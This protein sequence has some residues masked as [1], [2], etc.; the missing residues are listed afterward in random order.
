MAILQETAVNGTF[1][2]AK[3]GDVKSIA[4]PGDAIDWANLDYFRLNYACDSPVVVSYELPRISC[5]GFLVVAPINH[6]I[7]APFLN[8]ID[9]GWARKLLDDRDFYSEFMASLEDF[10]IN[11]GYTIHSLFAPYANFG[12]YLGGK[13][14]AF[15]IIE[16]PVNANFRVGGIVLPNYIFEEARSRAMEA[17]KRDPCAFVCAEE[18]QEYLPSAPHAFNDFG[19]LFALPTSRVSMPERTDLLND[20]RDFET[21]WR[22]D[23]P[24]AGN[25]LD[26]IRG[27]LGSSFSGPLGPS[28]QLDYE[29]GSSRLEC[30]FKFRWTPFISSLATMLH[31]KLNGSENEFVANLRQRFEEVLRHLQDSGRI[32]KADKTTA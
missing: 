10:G 27:M 16:C 5:S 2:I 31:R 8:G 25:Y 24:I 3:L 7:A 28:D 11:S 32:E 22:V 26:F 1:S 6:A 14:R 12:A 15:K 21:T 13:K 18:G 20:I 29:I 19:R 9:R 17:L 23:R 30:L 4:L